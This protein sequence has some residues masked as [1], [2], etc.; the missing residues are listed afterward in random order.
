M[1]IYDS[2]VEL[3][4]KKNGKEEVESVEWR[5]GDWAEKELPQ[6]GKNIGRLYDAFAEGKGGFQDFEG[7]AK[8]HA[9]I[10]KILNGE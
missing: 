3:K 6:Q 7:A 1:S 9:F 4:L 5:N 10:D 2:D 8:L